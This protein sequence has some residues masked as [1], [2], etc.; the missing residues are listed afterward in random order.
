GGALNYLRLNTGGSSLLTVFTQLGTGIDS[1]YGLDINT[2]RD[3]LVLNGGNNTLSH[4]NVSFNNQG[5]ILLTNGAVAFE[6]LSGASMNTAGTI[7]LAGD[8]CDLNFGQTTQLN[9]LSTGTIIKSGSGTGHLTG[10][11]GGSSVSTLN[12]GTIHVS[13]GTLIVN[14]VDAFNDNGFHN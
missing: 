3:T 6:N 12:N 14:S 5:T 7:E 1:F 4:G 10:T 11:F 8:T 9:N 2:S 13:G